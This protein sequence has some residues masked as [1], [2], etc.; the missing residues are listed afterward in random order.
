M[1]FL[2]ILF[3]GIGSF[4]TRSSHALD[5]EDSTLRDFVLEARTD[6]SAEDR[7][8]A[9]SDI[10]SRLRDLGSSSKVKE[11]VAEK[12]AEIAIDEAR[13]KLLLELQSQALSK[14][15][16]EDDLRKAFTFGAISTAATNASDGD[17]AATK[18]V[19]LQE[20]HLQGDKLAREVEDA[21][22]AR[23]EL[24]KELREAEEAVQKAIRKTDS[25]F[26][27]LKEADRRRGTDME[28][29]AATEA[30]I[31][32]SRAQ[33][34]LAEAYRAKDA[35][36]QRLKPQ[37]DAADSL[38][39]EKKEAHK[40]IKKQ[41]DEAYAQV[42]GNSKIRTTFG[43]VDLEVA[44][45]KRKDGKGYDVAFNV[46][47]SK[48]YFSSIKNKQ[49]LDK[50]GP[51]KIKEEIEKLREK[52]GTKSVV[53]ATNSDGQISEES[54]KKAL[55]SAHRQILLGS[56]GVLKDTMAD[57]LF[58]TDKSKEGSA[59]AEKYFELSELSNSTERE[60]A[61]RDLLAKRAVLAFMRANNT[62]GMDFCTIIIRAM[63]GGDG[64]KSKNDGFKNLPR[65][66]KQDCA[67]H[68]PEL[69]AKKEAEASEEDA[70]AKAEFAEQMQ[71]ENAALVGAIQ[72]CRAMAQSQG[73][74][75]PQNQSLV[76]AVQPIY[77]AM[78]KKGFTSEFYAQMIGDSLVAG[79]FNDITVNT[80]DL[81]GRAGKIVKSTPRTKEGNEKLLSER[82]TN[83]KIMQIA[84]NTLGMVASASP[85][86]LNEPQ[87]AQD[88]KVMQLM[89]AL[90]NSTAVVTAIDGALQERRDADKA[91]Y[92]G[93]S[94]SGQL[95][96]GAANPAVMSPVTG[97]QVGGGAAS[98]GSIQNRP[99]PA[100]TRKKSPN[101]NGQ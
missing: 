2:I 23:F 71:R 36:A 67:E 56:E 34:E 81:V 20:L 41:W 10:S 40:E 13:H 43:A 98:A 92:F 65:R 77:E 60:D 52:L 39:A 49:V 76:D 96:G 54:W 99:R 83:A 3:L 46:S 4:C 82:E 7:K 9:M 6:L 1:P 58:E 84:A 38:L 73:Q 35:V 47:P 61:K 93:G 25:A 42:D 74:Q 78:L 26:E 16:S 66:A 8:S 33:L 55:G 88:P 63:G 32:A 51:E 94:N 24:A 59:L 12:K 87:I 19:R 15:N 29:P 79:A 69:I 90:A 50:L 30:N 18:A 64:K 95:A 5:V 11:E 44:L 100:V 27:L 97:G 57:L 21:K 28:L 31:F 45:T 53:M 14:F 86:G 80:D 75:Q 68:D 72:G 48:D 17:P 37:L 85:M 62:D 89:K 101:Y 91:K 22:T 70:R